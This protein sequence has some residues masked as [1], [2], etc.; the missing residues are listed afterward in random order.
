MVAGKNTKH[1][2]AVYEFMKFWNSK[3]AQ[4]Y[5]SSKSGF[6][7][8][9]TDLADNALIKANPLVSQF[10]AV[11]NDSKFYLPG[12]EQYAKIDSDIV[13][14]AIQAITNKKGT[15]EANMAD[16]SKKLDALLQGK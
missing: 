16:A 13:T 14:P 15:V 11:A 6:P 5:L 4:A 10:A 8:T 12:L 1:K 2:D 7:P 3:D 9:R